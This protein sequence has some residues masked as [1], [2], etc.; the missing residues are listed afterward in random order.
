MVKMRVF[1]YLGASTSLTFL[2][3][4][5]GHPLVQFSPQC[6]GLPGG[7]PCLQAAVEGVVVCRVQVQLSAQ[8]TEGLE[9][10]FAG[11]GLDKVLKQFPHIVPL[12]L[13]LS[14]LS[15]L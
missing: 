8:E 10:S 9:A 1:S 7:D 13:H 4:L 5:V 11:G 14:H 2:V 6:F 15:F 12:L 3:L